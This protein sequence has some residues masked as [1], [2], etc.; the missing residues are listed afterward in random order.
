VYDARTGRLE[1]VTPGHTGT[2]NSVAWSPDS[3]QLA[4]ASEDGTARVFDLDGSAAREIVRLAAQDMRNGVRSVAFSP[5]GRELMTSDWAITSVKV[6][7]VT[8]EAAPEI[9]NLTGEAGSGCGA[10]PT[11]DGRSVWVAEGGGRVGRYDIATGRREQRLPEPPVGPTFFQCLELSPDGQLLAVMSLA[12]PFPVWDTRTGKVAFVVGEGMQGDVWSIDWDGSGE[13]LAV[14]VTRGT[15]SFYE[16]Q[17]HVVDRTGAELGR[18]S[19]EPDIVIPAVAFRGDGEAIAT[20]A[21]ALRD[22]PAARGIRTWDWRDDRL[23]GRI[24]GNAFDV[25]FDPSGDLLASTRLAEGVVDVWD[26]ATEARVSSLESHTGV[27]ND[28]AFD[29]TGQRLAT[30]SADGS[31]R[32]W[33]PTS[34]EEQVALRLATRVGAEGVAFSPDGRHLVT[35]WADGTTRIW[36]LDLDELVGIARDRV[37]RELTTAE[38]QQYLHVDG[39]PSS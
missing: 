10:T 3:S 5:D 29:P 36:T 37:T 20:T 6:W 31:V 13:R 23:L 15:R 14:S 38:C 7:D 21:R 33:D 8:D 11:P 19:G 9:A 28:L 27:I 2:V 22:E 35:T 30:A 12:L 39:C 17:V 26:A 1:L 18:V 34:G 4:T 32:V 24:D 16:S 25:V